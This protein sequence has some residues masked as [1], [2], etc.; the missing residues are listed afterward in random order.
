MDIKLTFG[1]T[2]VSG[3]QTTQDITAQADPRH[4]VDDQMKALMN[5]MFIQYATVGIIRQGA[6]EDG[7]PNPN[8]Y[9]LLCPSQ[10]AMVE[11]ELPSIILAGANEVPKITLD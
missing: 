3:E 1:L 10:I 6:N 7:T 11:C 5:R 2:F 4:H 8:R 9:M